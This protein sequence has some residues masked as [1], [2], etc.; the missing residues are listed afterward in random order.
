MPDAGRPLIDAAPWVAALVWLPVGAGAGLG[1]R[2]LSVRLARWERLEPG[3]RP[4]QV[5]G[6]MVATSLLFAA[7]AARY[8]LS[9]VLLIRSLWAAL[10]VQVIF[11]DLEH[12]LILDR[13]LVPAAVAALLLSFVVPQPGWLQAILTGLG[14]GL[15]FLSIAAVGSFVFKAE[16]MGLGDVKF[17]AL[18]GLM[19]GFPAILSAVFSGVIL[20][21]LVA[22]VLVVLR[23]RTMR[24]SI[25]Y[26]PF[27][28][29]GALLALFRPPGT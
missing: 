10:L 1:V 17:S 26:G 15:V 21:G 27:L 23:L 24:D 19:L 2:W 3:A 5:Y 13:V 14:T 16:A 7:F 22:V 11:F 8:G 18:M 6:P 12:H 9:P 28:A 29:M 4:W 25:A 20:A